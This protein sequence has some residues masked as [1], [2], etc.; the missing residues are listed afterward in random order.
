MN[1][2]L[3]NKVGA[4]GLPLI[5]AIGMITLSIGLSIN[6]V[7]FNENT[8]LSNVPD[9]YKAL[10]YAESGSRDALRLL[11]GDYGAITSG[12]TDCGGL[13]TT[14]STSP[15]YLIDFTSDSTGCSSTNNGC[16]RV[17][18]TKPN[19]ADCPTTTCSLITSEGRVKDFIRKIEAEVKFSTNSNY[20]NMIKSV[21]WEEI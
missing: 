16:A 9:S 15:C 2:L 11:A 1:K 19:T 12:G 20:L 17:K 10:S 8:T 4:L 3:K 13:N 5:L 7:S 21:T 18:I 14:P 6:L